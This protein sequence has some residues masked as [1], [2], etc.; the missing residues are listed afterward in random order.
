LV[1]AVEDLEPGF[2][3]YETPS[4]ALTLVEQRADARS[5]AG[6]LVLDERRGADAAACVFLLA[7]LATILEH[8]GNRG[9]RVAQ[10]EAGIMAGNLYLAATAIG[11]GVTG[12][13]FY[14]AEADRQIQPHAPGQ[15]TM[16]AVALGIAD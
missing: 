4:G 11:L 12:L 14:D 3:R 10:L 7:D 15:S 9:Y 2:Y 13:T 8:L 5:I 1:N 6:R 16:L